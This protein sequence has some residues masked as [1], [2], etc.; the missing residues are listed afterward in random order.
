[1]RLQVIILTG[2]MALAGEQLLGPIRTAFQKH[3][4][5]IRDVHVKIVLAETG[6]RAG[7]IGAAAAA[8]QRA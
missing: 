2:G 6:N 4:W 3:H 8:R 7:M 5:S 1:V